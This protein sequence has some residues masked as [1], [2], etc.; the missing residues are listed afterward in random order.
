MDDDKA[1]QILTKIVQDN[2]SQNLND[3]LGKVKGEK[4]KNW[5]DNN[6]KETWEII[7]ANKG[8]SSTQKSPQQQQSKPQEQK[9]QQKQ[10]QQQQPQQPQEQKQPRQNVDDLRKSL[11]NLSI[12]PVVQAAPIVQP[13]PAP[14]LS[15][16]PNFSRI[17]PSIPN[18]YIV[19][20]IPYNLTSN[21]QPNPVVTE[22]PIVSRIIPGLTQTNPNEFISKLKSGVSNRPETINL[23]KLQMPYVISPRGLIPTKT[24]T[25]N[26]GRQNVIDDAINIVNQ[27]GDKLFPKGF[28]D[29]FKSVF[30][31]VKYKTGVGNLD[32]FKLDL[33]DYTKLNNSLAIKTC[34]YMLSKGTHIWADFIYTF[35]K[36]AYLMLVLVNR[37]LR[38]KIITIEN[39][40]F[41]FFDL[42]YSIGSYNLNI[43]SLYRT[44]MSHNRSIYL[45]VAFN[46]MKEFKKEDF[47][48]KTSQSLNYGKIDKA[49]IQPYI[50][51]LIVPLFYPDLTNKSSN[52]DHILRYFA[53]YSNNSAIYSN[54][55]FLT[56]HMLKTG[57]EN[58]KKIISELYQNLQNSDLYELFKDSEIFEDV[59]LTD[60]A[61][62]IVSDVT[63]SLFGGE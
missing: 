45:S 51:K 33:D 1:K 31:L 43:V 58:I 3:L 36:Y 59:Y 32:S 23:D 42:S 60:I 40:P 12:K 61:K 44:L 4:L 63:K 14:N 19:N 34:I 21:V 16:I 28:I 37:L 18:Q 52:F 2:K 11:N 20:G 5:V 24:N 35:G 30:N 9:Q 7:N 27:V 55:D 39:I 50:Y 62:G 6:K 48:D 26:V 8:K 25:I 15:R 46:G 13:I 29:M 38:N 53:F 57:N 22:N 49:I 10:Q 41:E 54:V 17:G 56:T 47:Y